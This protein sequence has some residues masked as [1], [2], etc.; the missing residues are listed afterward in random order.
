MA[1]MV[2]VLKDGQVTLTVPVEI[3]DGVL[4]GKTSAGVTPLVNGF[5]LE[6]AGIDKSEIGK[7]ARSGDFPQAILACCLVMGENAG[8]RLVRD[9]DEARRAADAAMS[10][11]EREKRKLLSEIASVE[12]QAR[13]CD[14]S[15]D[16]EEFRRLT[17]KAERLQ[18]EFYDRFPEEKIADQARELL[19]RAAHRR[20]LAAG[21][22]VYDCDG[23]LSYQ[24]QVR[25]HDELIAEATKLESQ[26]EELGKAGE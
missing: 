21:A 23:S 14:R 26:A 18:K 2:E 4:W 9:K 6:K 25:R 8:G 11:V 12:N 16:D 17:W 22:M 15:E 19:S 20:D 3:R 13:R 1:M 24:D 10:P 5:L 7:C